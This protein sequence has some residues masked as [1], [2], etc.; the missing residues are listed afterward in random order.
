MKYAFFD[1]SFF[2]QTIFVEPS[3]KYKTTQNEGNFNE[4]LSQD[5]S[6]KATKEIVGDGA[7]NEQEGSEVSHN[8]AG[9]SLPVNKLRQETKVS[10]VTTSTKGKMSSKGLV[11]FYNLGNTCYLNSALQC[12]SHTPQLTEVT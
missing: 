6:T 9:S 8:S 12:L 3:E 7:D 5:D 11:G 4:S 1:A 10:D 2:C